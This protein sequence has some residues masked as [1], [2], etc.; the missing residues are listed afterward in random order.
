VTSGLG[1]F[2]ADLDA[3]PTPGANDDIVSWQL[4]ALVS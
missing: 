1:G 3:G 2:T 4:D